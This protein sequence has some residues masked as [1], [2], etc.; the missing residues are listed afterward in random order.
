VLDPGSGRLVVAGGP[1]AS[2]DAGSTVGGAP[3]AVLQMPGPAA[4]TVL[5]ET[6]TALLSVD[7]AHGTVSTLSTVKSAVP[8]AAVRFDGCVHAVWGGASGGYARGCG[9]ASVTP[10]NLAD[11]HGLSRPVFRINRNEI[12]LNDLGDGR[13]WDL[14]NRQQVD[15][16]LAVH[17]LH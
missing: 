16:W 1:S 11:T 6:A 4:T 12:V 3:G 10:V 9:T 5:A 8:A 15:D 17:P 13:V 14:T 7:L 2:L